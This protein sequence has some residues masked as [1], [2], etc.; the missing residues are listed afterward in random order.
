MLYGPDDDILDYDD[1]L[2]DDDIYDEDFPD[3]EYGEE[4][5][6]IENNFYKDWFKNPSRTSMMW[7]FEFKDT[8]DKVK[9]SV[10]KGAGCYGT[11]ASFMNTLLRPNRN[12]EKKLLGVYTALRQ[13][14]QVLQEA[15][16][17]YD[18]IFNP[19]E[20]PWRSVLKGSK[21]SAGTTEKHPYLYLP[22][23]KGDPLQ[24]VVSLF[25]AARLVQDNPDSIRM[26]DYLVKNGYT[27][28]QAL[29][30][31]NYLGLRDGRVMDISWL[32]F[33]AFSAQSNLDFQ[34]LLKAEPRIEK[35]FGAGEGHSY[36]P[37]Q[38]MW[39][40]ADFIKY[41][42]WRGHTNSHLVR[43]KSK[44]SIFEKLTPS[45][46]YDGIFPEQFKAMN[47]GK[48]ESEILREMP[49]KEKLL[50]HK[51]YIFKEVV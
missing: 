35:G 42:T 30:V 32:D 43:D 13:D 37:L 46:Q 15:Q 3:D 6:M 34:R 4:D 25:L 17:Y 16:S 23:S 19:K 39:V 27:G 8:D 40:A 29:Y 31:S 18:F 20:S 10:I 24:P 38:T 2:Y 1:D 45:K 11:F 22:L 21:Y 44:V 28:V 14:E 48:L 9:Y 50:E 49:S 36:G 33:N 7:A 5:I 51:D 41:E 47:G 26:F 12:G